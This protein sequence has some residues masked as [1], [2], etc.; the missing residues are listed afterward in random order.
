M[1]IKQQKQIKGYLV[2]EFG[3][4]KG[5]EFFSNEEKILNTII[6]NTH[7]KT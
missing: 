2:R 1:K 7:K 5:T 3:E 4:E 6:A